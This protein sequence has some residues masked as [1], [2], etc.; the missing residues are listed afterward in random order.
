MFTTVYDRLVFTECIPRL[1]GSREKLMGKDLLM[2]DIAKPEGM[3]AKS[4]NVTMWE[5]LDEL[6]DKIMNPENHADLSVLE[7]LKSEARGLAF[8]LSLTM[9][10]L[11][12]S[13]DEISKESLARYRKRKAGEDHT[14]PC[15][16]SRWKENPVVMREIYVLGKD[17]SEVEGE[18]I[19][20][21]TR[22]PGQQPPHEPRRRAPVKSTQ[23][24]RV[25][26]RS[27]R[28]RTGGAAKQYP[29]NM[30]ESIRTSTAPPDQIA[31]LFGLSVE[32]IKNIRTGKVS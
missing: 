14:T 16:G 18:R 12:V 8:A 5:K 31:T 4:L 27:A 26:A 6:M 2:F 17:P 32:E 11:F 20:P 29:P 9:K 1:D 15:T 7:R 30:I 10:P 21:E 3:P 28:G 13:V 24:E 22:R 19:M 23:A 25:L